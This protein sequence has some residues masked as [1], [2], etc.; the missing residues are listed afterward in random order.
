MKVEDIIEGLNRHI[1]EKRR[2]LN[3][4]TKGHL[5]LQKLITPNPT[6]KT[7]KVCEITLWFVKSSKK[8]KLLNI[9]QTVK[10]TDGQEDSINR[11]M[12]TLLSTKLFAFIGTKEYEQ[13]IKG[14]YE[15]IKI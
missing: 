6:F 15:T 10:M 11:D 5:V 12:N 4:S 3:I 14:S 8:H 9:S 2:E 13:I 1:E 7:Y